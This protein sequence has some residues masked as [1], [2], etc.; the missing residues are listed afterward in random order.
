MQPICSHLSTHSCIYNTS[1]LL[2]FLYPPTSPERRACD[3]S[4]SGWPVSGGPWPDPFSSLGPRIR[5]HLMQSVGSRRQPSAG[6][7]PLA[8]PKTLLLQRKR[9]I[10]MPHTIP[11]LTVKKKRH[12]D[13]QR[14]PKRQFYSAELIFSLPS[15][16]SHTQEAPKASKGLPRDAQRTVRE[17]SPNILAAASRRCN[18]FLL[19]RTFPTDPQCFSSSTATRGTATNKWPA[20][21]PLQ[22]LP[23]RPFCAKISKTET[24]QNI[25][26]VQIAYICI[27]ILC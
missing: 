9:V 5:C 1:Q 14:F 15:A 20:P 18:A 16:S 4:I 26:L 11:N 23:L 2:P 10:L 19:R 7:R 6:G 24:Y 3:H 12:V 13:P 17:A 22:P 25:G 27:H 21:G 8:G